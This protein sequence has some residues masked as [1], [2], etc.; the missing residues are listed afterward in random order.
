MF[1]FK[2]PNGVEKYFDA[3]IKNINF[4]FFN[5]WNYNHQSADFKDAKVDFNVDKFVSKLTDVFFIHLKS[6]KKFANQ[7][8]DILIKD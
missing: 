6:G 1:N 4:R 2:F 5:E 8:S 7:L 3:E